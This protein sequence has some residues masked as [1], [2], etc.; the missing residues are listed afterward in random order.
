MRRI[1]LFRK[2][3]FAFI[4]ALAVSI[5]TQ[6]ASAPVLF[7]TDLTV[8]PNTG[9]TDTTFTSSGNGVYVGI[10]GNNLG[11][12]QGT[13]TITWNGQSCL[14]VVGSKGTYAGWGTTHFWYQEIIVQIMSTCTAATGNFVV[15]TSAGTSNGLSFTVNTIGSNHIYFAATTGSDSN[16]GTFSAPFGSIGK[17]LGSGTSSI[18]IAGDVCYIE[19]GLS[20]TTQGGAFSALT[21]SDRN[22]TA[23]LPI[24]LVTY[25]GGT[26]NVGSNSLDKG[27]EHCTTNGTCGG[28][29][30]TNTYI[31]VAGFHVRGLTYAISIQSAGN[32]YVANEVQCPSGG[33]FAGCFNTISNSETILGN[34]ISNGTANGCGKLCHNLYV[35]YPTNANG[36]GYEV[37]WNYS[38]NN[39]G[40]GR[41]VQ[42][43]NGSQAGYNIAFH[44]NLLAHNTNVDCSTVDAD[45]DLGYV[46][47]YNNVIY[48]CGKAAS[49]PDWGGS[50]CLYLQNSTSVATNPAQIYN[51]TFYDCG[52]TSNPNGFGAINPSAKL[53]LTNNI[54]DQTNASIPYFFA[55][56]MT[57]VS[58]VNNV[59]NG[60]GNGP[61]QTTGNVNSDP[62]LV[63]PGTDF[64]IQSTSPAKSAG[65]GTLFPTYD[66][67]GLTRPNPP[68]I[69][70]YEFASAPAPP[71]APAAVLFA[72]AIKQI[73]GNATVK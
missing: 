56:S 45:A 73:S 47:I 2:L 42:F 15:T 5:G 66:H 35:G 8:G 48:D 54:L 3:L 34:E 58:G 29:D 60:A 69:G 70:A 72:G 31:T 55:G 30:T 49:S 16:A 63:N 44:D 17:C 25:P 59:Y 4:L 61:T 53:T 40:G 32:R 41:L 46:R 1:A 6:A 33:S 22:G 24:A 38:H 67:D 39:N 51:N 19:D 14:T 9:N 37:G 64:H 11:A 50:T 27:I 71:P 52:T 62:L 57:N 21:I 36:F 10:Y 12:T 43:F 26:S 23:S 28:T 65:S 13:S 18:M 20:Q 7:F 68:S